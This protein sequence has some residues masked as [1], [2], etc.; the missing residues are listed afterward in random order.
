MMF[1]VNSMVLVFFIYIVVAMFIYAITDKWWKGIFWPLLMIAPFVLVFVQ[2][3]AL[4]VGYIGFV[5]FA[6]FIDQEK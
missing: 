3:I 6:V 1:G 5:L 4:V 2:A